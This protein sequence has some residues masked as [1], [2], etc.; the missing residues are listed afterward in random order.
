MLEYEWRL[1]ELFCQRS[2][3]IGICQYHADALPREAMRKGI[4]AHPALFISKTLSKDNPY[5]RQPEVFTEEP[6]KNPEVG[7]VLDQIYR[8]TGFN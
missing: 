7:G 1:E 8:R 6:E 4:L 5:Y 2:E 3:L